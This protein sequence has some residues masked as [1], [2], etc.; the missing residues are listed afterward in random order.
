MI[1][2]INKPKKSN[3][4]TD[5]VEQFVPK[6]GNIIDLGCGWG[7]FSKVLYDVAHHLEESVQFK[8]LEECYR[9]YFSDCW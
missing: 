4:F 8:V 3:L 1:S 5:C 6:E 9:L 2:L 7:I